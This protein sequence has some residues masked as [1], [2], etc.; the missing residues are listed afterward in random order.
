MTLYYED[1]PPSLKNTSTVL[2]G[3]VR[4]TTAWLPNNMN[5]SRLENLYWLLTVMATVNF[6]YYL[7][8][9]KLYKYKNVGK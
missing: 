4:R 5:A 9:A 7:L 3:V 8:C 1:F 6:G 2:V